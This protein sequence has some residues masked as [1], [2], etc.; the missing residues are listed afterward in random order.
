MENCRL[1]RRIT[2]LMPYLNTVFHLGER[3]NNLKKSPIKTEKYVLFFTLQG[4]TNER[5]TQPN[6]M[7][8]IDDDN[9]EQPYNIR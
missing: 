6:I 3:R 2:I 1:R 8:A 5:A 7:P 4:N 9:I